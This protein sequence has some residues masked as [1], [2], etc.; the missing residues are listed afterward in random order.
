MEYLR[1]WGCGPVE[2]PSGKEALSILRKSVS[3]RDPFNLILTDIQMSEMSGF[4]LA[5]E[6]RRLEALKE[7][8]IIALTSVGMIGDGKRC[9]DT[10]IDGYLTKPIKQ[11]DLYR[12]I[13][14]VLSSSR[15][16]A[17]IVPKLVTKHSIAE[18][19]RKEVQI[20]LVE[21]YPT[22]QQ[23][24]MRHLQGAGYQVDL[25]EN[26]Q[27]AVES[28]RRKHYD[29]ILMDIQMPVMDGYEAT[30]EIRKL[31]TRNS[32]GQVSSIKHPVSSVP[33]IAMTAHATKADRE[34]A[35]EAGMDDYVTKP[36]KRKKFLAMVEKWS[37]MILDFGL[38]NAD[39]KSKI[40]NPK[41]NCLQ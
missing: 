24:A 9:R 15:A 32:E 28:Y 29:I 21:D 23:V 35:F 4:D 34:R 27:Q 41:S 20:L 38:R 33:I 36:L 13:L 18:E 10:E 8:P 2:A 12:A 37:M 11:D 26:G 6:I 40:Q 5:T 16:E 14:S 31:E 17:R 3:S 22:N 19:Y 7:I 1:S 39:L 25:V 30:K